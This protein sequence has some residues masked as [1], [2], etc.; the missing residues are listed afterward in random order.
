M[1]LPGEARSLVLEHC[2][3]ELGQRIVLHTVV[4]MPD[5]VHLHFEIATV[6]LS[7]WSVSCSAWFGG[8]TSELPQAGEI[9]TWGRVTVSVMV[10]KSV[11]DERRK[12]RSKSKAAGEGARSTRAF[13]SCLLRSLRSHRLYYRLNPINMV[14][15]EREDNA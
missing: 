3:R 5:H 14:I 9:V 13:G 2:L 12:S 11:C 10:V 15:W 6:G 1:I 7:P 4:V 8:H